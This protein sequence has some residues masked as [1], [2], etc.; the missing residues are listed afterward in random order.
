MSLRD[1]PKVRESRNADHAEENVEVKEAKSVVVAMRCDAGNA[2]RNVLCVKQEN[3][4]V[5]ATESQRSLRTRGGNCVNF[6]AWLKMCA[7]K[8]VGAIEWRCC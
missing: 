3:E 5:S 4:K 1:Q 7:S 8:F 2:L 6:K